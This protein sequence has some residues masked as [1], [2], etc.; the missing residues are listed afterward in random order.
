M[1]EL[2]LV[3]ILFGVLIRKAVPMTPVDKTRLVK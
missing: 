3:K 1:V 2:L